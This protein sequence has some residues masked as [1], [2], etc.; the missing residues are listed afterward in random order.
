MLKGVLKMKYKIKTEEKK[1]VVMDKN[2][3]IISKW[4]KETIDDAGGLEKC[5]ERFKKANPKS[6][7]EMIGEPAPEPTPAPAPEPEPTPAPAPEPEPTPAPEPEPTPAP[8]PEP[9]PEPAPVNG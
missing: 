6:E 9:T 3:N 7:I 5:I 4:S 1:Y 2:D 8:E